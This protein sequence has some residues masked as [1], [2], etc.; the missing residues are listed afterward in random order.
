MCEAV[1]KYGYEREIKAKS[2]SVKNLMKNLK[3]TLNQALDTLDILGDERD[4]VIKE[5]Q[6]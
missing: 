1:E 2:D 3:L 5:L 6:K 4:L